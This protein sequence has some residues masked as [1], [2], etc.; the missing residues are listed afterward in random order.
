MQVLL[1][2]YLVHLGSNITQKYSQKLIIQCISVS[3]VCSKKNLPSRLCQRHVIPVEQSAIV[4]GIKGLKNQN[5]WILM[6]LVFRILFLSLLNW[7]I[8]SNCYFKRVLVVRMCLIRS[9][10][11]VSRHF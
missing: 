3:Y 8:I 4:K 7:Y 10:A 11:I 5:L 6:R 2:L 1:I 9:N